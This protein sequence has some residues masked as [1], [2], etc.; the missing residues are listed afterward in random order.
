MLLGFAP[1]AFASLLALPGPAPAAAPC[2]VPATPV[3]APLGKP[4]PLPITLKA[5]D[6]T[7]LSA[8]YYA[9]MGVKDE[10][11]PGV[12]LVHDQGRTTDDLR[13]LAETLASKGLGVLLLEL[14]AHGANAKPD[15]NWKDSDEKQQKAIWAFASKDVQAG[16]EFLAGRKELHRSKLIVIGHGKGCSLAIE[17]ALRNHNT[18]ATVLIEPA[19]KV[20]DFD[21]TK[22]LTELDGIPTLLVCGK[23]GKKEMAQVQ[24]ACTPKNV[25]EPSCE[26]SCLSS[27]A[28]KVLEDK[29]LAKTVFL[30]LA[31]H[32]E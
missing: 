10:L 32:M 31:Q 8:D 7:E 30:F 9:P 17:Q 3:V 16:A 2:V 1:L 13:D 28:E 11:V 15:Y 20:Y 18:L 25:A 12:L 22:S 24:E 4:Q 26:V 21:L 27:P 14:R 29:K 19:K 23:G 6:K 5:D